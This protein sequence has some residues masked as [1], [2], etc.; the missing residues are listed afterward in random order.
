MSR[1]SISR[2][3]LISTTTSPGTTGPGWVITVEGPAPANRRF[4]RSWITTGPKNVPGPILIKSPLADL[5]TAAWMVKHAIGGDR[6][7]FASFPVVE[8]KRFAPDAAVPNRQTKNVTR[9]QVMV[10]S[11]SRQ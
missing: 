1:N 8:T 5:V 7:L 2:E 4:D 10:E 9:K 11:T 3:V 6:Q